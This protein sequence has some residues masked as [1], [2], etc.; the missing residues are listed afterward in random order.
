MENSCLRLA[1]SAMC[2]HLVC[3]G[4]L[5]TYL[6]LRLIE[7]KRGLM[8]YAQAVQLKW[9][10]ASGNRDVTPLLGSFAV[11]NQEATPWYCS[12]NCDCCLWSGQKW[13]REVLCR[14]T[15]SCDGSQEG[16]RC[17]PLGTFQ[18]LAPGPW[19][20]HLTSSGLTFTSKEETYLPA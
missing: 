3:C 6:V 9:R 11:N 17:F 8:L 16:P 14:D 12:H 1:I 7:I 5:L 15:V 19:W 13:N 20:H 4:G 10:V 18:P 2:S